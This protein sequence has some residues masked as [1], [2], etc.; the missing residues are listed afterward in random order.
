MI[1]GTGLAAWSIANQ[2]TVSDDDDALG[3]GPLFGGSS[4]DD[5]FV[6]KCRATDDDDSVA[7]L[8]L[9]HGGSCPCGEQTG[10]CVGVRVAT[11]PD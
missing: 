10:V 6:C 11:S 8:G 1:N 4:V 7:D 5:L 2:F 3:S 9:V